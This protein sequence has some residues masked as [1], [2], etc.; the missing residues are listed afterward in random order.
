MD[1]KLPNA[2]IRMEM[3]PF[4]KLGFGLDSYLNLIRLLIFAMIA[5]SILF[6]P[7]MIFYSGYHSKIGD[8]NK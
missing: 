7:H 1:L 4:M 3:D 2:E 5:L 8:V 6:L